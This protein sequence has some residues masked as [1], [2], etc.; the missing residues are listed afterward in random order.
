MPSFTQF[1]ASINYQFKGYLKGTN[2]QFLFV[3]KNNQGDIYDT[4]RYVINKVNMS[5]LNFI[6]NHQF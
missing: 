1:T 4:E 3:N 2:A 6:L 5:Q